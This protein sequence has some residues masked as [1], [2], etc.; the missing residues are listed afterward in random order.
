[1]R[2]H[3]DAD[4]VWARATLGHCSMADQR[5]VWPT[6]REYERHEAGGACGQ[7]VVKKGANDMAGVRGELGDEQLRHL[8]EQARHIAVVGLSPRPERPSYQVAEYLMRQGYTI[9]P[10]NPTQLGQTILGM[11]VYASIQAV[12]EPPDIIDVFRRSA[13]VGAVV[14]DALAARARL[15]TDAEANRRGPLW[16]LWTQLGVINDEA[17]ERARAAGMAVVHDRCL[18]VEHM[19]LL[20]PQQ[21]AES[22]RGM[23]AQP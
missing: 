19:R 23:S 4:D 18:K 13:Y 15:R 1:M 7:P 6:N 20:G 3:R 9:I 8:L 14:D 21:P 22:E 12:P 2:I 10:V 16:T 17:F 11:P 5:V